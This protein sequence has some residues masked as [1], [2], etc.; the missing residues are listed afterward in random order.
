MRN[1]D[2]KAGITII[3]LAA[4][5]LIALVPWY[6]IVYG[7]LKPDDNEKA[8]LPDVQSASEASLPVEETPPVSEPISPD[9]P[10]PEN[11]SESGEVVSNEDR[12]VDISIEYM[13]LADELY[14]VASSH[15][16]VAVSLA[17]YDG[18]TGEY[19]IYNYGHADVSQGRFVDNNTKF[20]VASL[21]KLVTV[22]CA[23]VLVDEGLI[24][25]DS[26][27]S[28]YLG[29]EVVNPNFPEAIITTRMLMQ[30]TST[31]YDSGTFQTARDRNSA[32][33]P[34]SL[35]ESGSSFRRSQPGT[36]FEYTNFGYSVLGAVCENVSGKTLDTLARDVLFDPI[37]IDA[38]YVPSKLRSSENIAVIYNDRHAAT[39]SV[40]SQ[41]ETEE[42]GVPG[43]DLH[44]AQGNLTIRMIDYA[45]ILA[46]LGNGGTLRDVRVLSS[47]AVRAIHV[48]DVEGVAYRQ[49][50]ATRYTFGDFMPE[51]G[52]YWHT[53]SAYGTYAQYI[54]GTAGNTNRGV[55]AVTTGATTGREPNGM[56]SLCTKLSALVWEDLR[57]SNENDMLY[58]DTENE[59]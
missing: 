37:G 46:M 55:V 15:N 26:D 57:F 10:A 45:K 33:T 24:N 48:T 36:L 52:F 54:Y 19:F 56:V 23:M 42:S 18:K 50:L 27:I 29:Y 32:D 4:I 8:D 17:A 28:D 5:I 43:L 58:E 49:G 47:D 16:A 2:G 59:S 25:L 51:K 14:E 30:H 20:R 6:F 40:Q 53:G 34:Q 11:E 38:A 7:N 13:E 3:I 22:I 31:I 41:L 1:R 39:R 44:L 35:L 21:S 9:L 12:I